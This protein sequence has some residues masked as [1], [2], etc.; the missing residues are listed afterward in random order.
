MIGRIKNNIRHRVIC[1]LTN[2]LLKAVSEDDILRITSDGYMYRN[3]KLAPEEI[4]TLKQEAKMLSDSF[5]WKIM[6]KEVEYLAFMLMS[7]K[8]KNNEDV[9]FGKAVFYAIYLLKSFLNNLK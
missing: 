4:A 9:V 3:R 2:K 5:L 7:L 8:A 1:L 6:T